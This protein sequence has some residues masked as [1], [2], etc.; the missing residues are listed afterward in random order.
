MNSDATVTIGVLV[1]LI[2][3][4][5]NLY[6]FF[7]NFKGDKNAEALIRLDMK[8]DEINRTTKDM[9]FDMKSIDRRLEE[10]NIRVIKLEEKTKDL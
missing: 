5:I 2:G 7:K 8:L 10:L 1:L 3:C 4:A 9:K 6:N